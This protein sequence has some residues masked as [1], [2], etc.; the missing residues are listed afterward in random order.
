MTT[1]LLLVCLA[2]PA[3]AADAVPDAATAEKI[4]ADALKAKIGET[5]YS[6]LMKDME[7]RADT[8]GIV[9]NVSPL[10]RSAHDLPPCAAPPGQECVRIQAGGW[11]VRISHQ[12]GHVISIEREE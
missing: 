6:S 1:T 3:L 8:N 5:R 10:L 12:D 4:A 7:W 9:W 11:L 2:Q